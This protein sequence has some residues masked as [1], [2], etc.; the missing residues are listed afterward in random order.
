MVDSVEDP[1]DTAT[2]DNDARFPDL[3]ATAPALQPAGELPGEDPFG[4]HVPAE[5][6]PSEGEETH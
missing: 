1:D 2:V 4:R 5:C 6:C 3:E